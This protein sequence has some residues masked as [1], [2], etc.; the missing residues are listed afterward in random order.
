MSRICSK[1]GIRLMFAKPYSPE[2]TGKIERFNRVVDSFLSEAALEKPQTL[3]NLNQ[4]FWVWLNECYQNKA[5]SAL[6]N[7]MSPE[8]A[9]KSDPKALKYC[10]PETIT[11]AFLHCEERKVDKAGCLSFAGKKYEAGLKFIGCKVEVIY[12]PADISELTINY[13][14]HEPFKVK[15]LII[16]ERTG[17]RPKM[18]EHLQAKPAASSRLLSAASKK[19][20]ERKEIQ[21]P[22]VSYRTVR[23]GD[24]EDV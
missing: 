10:S 24:I 22:A 14:G 6:K 11:D 5:H 17:K 18:P 2:A 3:T 1:L 15:Q 16:G 20:R 23:K 19:N 13:P 21:I 7:N 4:L 9:F 12:D 8:T